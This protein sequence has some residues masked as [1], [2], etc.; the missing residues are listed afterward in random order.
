[1]LT[2]LTFYI[3]DTDSVEEDNVLVGNLP[4]H[5]RCFKEC[6]LESEADSILNC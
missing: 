3:P 2:E 4:H 1:M 5:A 6:L